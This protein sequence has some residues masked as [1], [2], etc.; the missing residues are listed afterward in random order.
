MIKMNG[1][2]KDFAHVVGDFNNWTLSNDESRRCIRDDASDV[3]DYVGGLDAG[4]EYAFQYYV[5]TK[6]GEVFIWQCLY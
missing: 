2:H 1:N 5:G 4:K 3:G 6:E